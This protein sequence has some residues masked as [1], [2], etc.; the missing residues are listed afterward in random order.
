MEIPIKSL[1]NALLG[2]RCRAGSAGLKSQTVK[3]HAE[4]MKI[5]SSTLSST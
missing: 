4:I 3:K 1:R 5:A 2:R